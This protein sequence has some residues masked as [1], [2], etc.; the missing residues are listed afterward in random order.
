MAASLG[1]NVIIGVSPQ[2]WNLLIGFP[3]KVTL[4]RSADVW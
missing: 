2:S 4:H 1:G 3:I